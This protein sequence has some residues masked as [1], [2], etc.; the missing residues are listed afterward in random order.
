MESMLNR[1]WRGA[2]VSVA[3]D[4]TGVGFLR[5][6]TNPFM[7]RK[8]N[9][10]IIARAAKGAALLL[11]I[12]GVVAFIGCQAATPTPGKD[13]ATGPQG[14]QGPKGDPGA[15]GPAGI[16]ALQVTGGADPQLIVFNDDDGE[17]GDLT[18]PAGEGTLDASTFFVG[19][20]PPLTFKGQGTL[21][22]SNDTD[23]FKVAVAENGMITVTKNTDDDGDAVRDTPI[24]AD[25]STGYTFT[26]RATDANGITADRS[27]R[28]KANRPPQACGACRAWAGGQTR[29]AL[30]SSDLIRPTAGFTSYSFFVGT[31]E[32]LEAKGAGAANVVT[33]K[34]AWNKFWADDDIN[35]RIGIHNRDTNYIFQDDD[36]GEVK[37]AI[38]EVGAAGP[39]DDE[40]Y[41]KV[42]L[43]EMGDLTVTGVKSTWNPDR[44]PTAAH[45]PIPVEISATDAGGLSASNLINIWVDGAPTTEGADVE[46]N[47]NYIIRKSDGANNL[48]DAV[49]TAFFKDPEGEAVAVSA[50]G[51]VTSS[52]PGVATVA[53]AADGDLTITPVNQGTTT[54]TV[55]VSSSIGTFYDA[56]TTVPAPVD[57]DND[58]TVDADDGATNA[59]NGALPGAQWGMASFQVT[60]IP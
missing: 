50:S 5:R 55:Y 34:R 37:F 10:M 54:I 9:H 41:V 47:A 40:E 15:P 4:S 57:R 51:S 7:E 38:V 31:Q 44:T 24:A 27:L 21:P 16:S 58:G 1:E 48:I 53:M 56:A 25:Y 45:K 3:T 32:K 60:V 6:K 33:E 26:V 29:A 30:T 49:G 59:E 11:M 13:G 39:A 28:V 2:I 20:A 22:G 42:E 52:K 8:E 23:T 19:G 43:S 17:I 36:P 14:D 18:T 46:F 12:F 35:R